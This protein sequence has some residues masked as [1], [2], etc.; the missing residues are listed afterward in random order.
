MNL[1]KILVV[2]D[3]PNIREVLSVL[4]SS[5]GYEVEEAEN[6]KIAIEKVYSGEAIDL[7]ILDIMLD[8]S[9]I[10]NRNF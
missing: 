3:D 6:G 7:I 5:E 1:N 10:R 4:L 2:D 9:E 8:I